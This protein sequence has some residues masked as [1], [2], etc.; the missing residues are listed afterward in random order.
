MT[1]DD[2]I[3][4][5][6]EAHE[7]NHALK[8]VPLEYALAAIAAEREACANIADD[9]ETWRDNPSMVIADTIRKRPDS[10]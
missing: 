10:K 8:V 4:R 6:G 5:S 7:F 2:L 1:K 9:H 3:Q